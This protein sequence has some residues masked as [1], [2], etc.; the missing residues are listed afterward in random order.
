MATKADIERLLNSNVNL[1]LDEFDVIAAMDKEKGVDIKLANRIED[2]IRLNAEY[3]NMKKILVLCVVRLKELSEKYENISPYLQKNA[4]SDLEEAIKYAKKYISA[5]D[6]INFFARTYKNDEEKYELITS[7]ENIYGEKIPNKND[8]YDKIKDLIPDVNSQDI[9]KL[10]DIFRQ[11]LGNPEIAREM[12]NFIASNTLSEQGYNEE[13]MSD[14]FSTKMD[15]LIEKVA[16]LVEISKY[17]VN[18]RKILEKNKRFIDADKYLLFV[19]HKIN[20]KLEKQEKLSNAD[21]KFLSNLDELMQDMPEKTNIYFDNKDEES[22]KRSK[23][24]YGKK[25]VKKFLSKF[26]FDKMEYCTEEQ[27]KSGEKLLEEI[28]GYEELLKTKELKELANIEQ[29]LRY[30]VLK[31]KLNSRDIMSILNNIDVSQETI[32]ILYEQGKISLEKVEEYAKS[33]NMNFQSIKHRIREKIEIDISTIG[34][35]DE[36]WELLSE[37]E[38]LQIVEKAIDNGTCQNRIS[39]KE[40]ERICNIGKIADIYKEIYLEGNSDNI[41]QY[42][43]LIKIYNALGKEN[44]DEIINLLEEQFSNEMLINLYK[45]NL[46]SMRILEDYGEEVMLQAFKEGRLK[47]EDL[48]MVLKKYHIKLSEEEVT[49]FYE[50]KII[51]TKDIMELY[52]DDK[53]KLET[54]K[55]LNKQLSEKDRFETYLNESEL[56]NLYRSSR[57][58]KKEEEKIRYKKYRLLYLAIENDNLEESE[59]TLKGMLE[60]YSDLNEEDIIQLYKDNILTLEIVLAY[61]NE[62]LVKKIATLGDL[63]PKDAKTIFKGEER[64]TFDIKE[65]LN[66]PNIEDTEKLILIYSTYDEDEDKEIREELVNYL[67]VHAT[68]MRETSVGDGENNTGEGTQKATKTITDPYERWKLFSRLDKNYNKKYIDGYLVVH[69]NNSQKSIVEKMYQKKN[70][71]VEPAH[72]NATFVLDE[73]EYMQIE[74]SLIKEERFDIVTLRKM[75]KENPEMIAKVTHHVNWGDRLLRQIGN[76]EQLKEIYTE[77]DMQEIRGCLKAVE[78]SREI[79]E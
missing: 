15:T 58:S 44:N 78:N 1:T 40:M 77:N 2:F 52:I 11:V 33:R 51:S 53:I 21:K 47:E 63:K 34:N 38:K 70:G 48:S 64:L 12:Y 69:L 73:E 4:K 5:K 76:E 43:R 17:D 36:K 67:H 65:L 20:E 26:N 56:I 74:K 72:G 9:Q 41:N 42:G 8:R 27:L 28:P 24:K 14:I 55:N 68:D 75:A 18:L 29:N 66:N 3:I 16:Q 19:A 71:K 45:D 32:A 23:T 22:R 49:K 61:G 31:N 54:L 13:Q 59:L 46:I 60:N 57:E 79:Y 25:D 37:E 50:L 6:D 30:L 10:Y 62:E 35:D 39:K 7:K